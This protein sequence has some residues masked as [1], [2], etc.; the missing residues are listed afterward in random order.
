MLGEPGIAFQTNAPNA[1]TIQRPKINIAFPDESKPRNT[2]QLQLLQ[3]ALAS[4]LSSN[5]ILPVHLPNIILPVH[6]ITSETRQLI[7]NQSEIGWNHI[8]KGCWSKLWI[9]CLN[10][11][12]GYNA[13]IVPAPIKEKNMQ[14]A[15]KFRY[16][17]LFFITG[18]NDVTFNIKMTTSRLKRIRTILTYR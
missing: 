11:S 3:W 13:L 12:C 1:D 7:T 6:L 8:L 16:G 14:S 4:Y 10:I 17:K 9:Q 18:G 2:N 5:I 15:Y